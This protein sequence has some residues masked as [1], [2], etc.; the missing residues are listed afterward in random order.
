MIIRPSVRPRHNL[1]KHEG[2]RSIWRCILHIQNTSIWVKGAL[3]L[4]ENCDVLEGG[5]FEVLVWVVHEHDIRIQHQYIV[6]QP[7]RPASSFGI[8]LAGH[9][10]SVNYMW[11]HFQWNRHM[12]NRLLVLIANGWYH[13]NW[14]CATK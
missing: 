5:L 8:K 2:C 9:A 6:A 1:S 7:D 12:D 4:V 11:R 3:C 14:S 13:F 10:I